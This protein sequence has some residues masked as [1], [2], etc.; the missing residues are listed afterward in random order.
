MYIRESS[1]LI[2]A[3]H[4][5]CSFE[6]RKKKLKQWPNLHSCVFWL[7]YT[8]L[9][10]YATTTTRPRHIYSVVLTTTRGDRT[11]VRL[12]CLCKLDREPYRV[13]CEKKKTQKNRKKTNTG[14]PG[15]LQRERGE[16][17]QNLLDSFSNSSSS[18]DKPPHKIL[19][20]NSELE[21]TGLYRLYH[22]Y[23]QSRQSLGGENNTLIAAISPR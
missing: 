21:L 2:F 10:H 7:K 20:T 5:K 3:P 8:L 16:N 17:W 14:E 1:K 15:S 19:A 23:G 13:S 12:E 9:R 18:V 11:R 6:K 4:K 22:G